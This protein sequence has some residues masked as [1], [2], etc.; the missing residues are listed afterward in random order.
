MARIDEVR[1]VPKYNIIDSSFAGINRVRCLR[2]GQ[3]DLILIAARAGVGKTM[4][5]TQIAYHVSKERPVMFFSLEM[6]KEQLK[7]RLVKGGIFCEGESF[8]DLEDSDHLNINKIVKL[9]EESHKRDHLGMVLVDYTQ[10]VKSVGQ[11]QKERVAYVCEQLKNLAKRLHCP[12]VGLC[13]LN[14]QIENREANEVFIPPQ[15]SDLADSDNLAHWADCIMIMHR[16]PKDKDTIKVHLPK[17]RH[18]RTIP[19]EL[20]MDPETGRLFDKEKF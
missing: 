10:I 4:L 3:P 17:F 11:N 8:L 13:Q 18:G 15:M 2:E 20:S 16:D 1:D 19:F 5:A 7:H 12:V 9:A 6:T 14:R